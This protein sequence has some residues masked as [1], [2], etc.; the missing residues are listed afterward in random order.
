MEGYL[1]FFESFADFFTAFNVEDVKFRGVAISLE[2]EK[3]NFQ[4]AVRSADWRVLIGFERI[5][6]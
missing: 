4:L 2:L 1:V 5:K 6:F 3:K